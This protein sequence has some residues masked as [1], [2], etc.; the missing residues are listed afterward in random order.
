MRSTR[1]TATVSHAPA[2]CDDAPLLQYAPGQGAQDL[3]VASLLRKS[4]RFDTRS[5]VASQ[6]ALGIAL[7][8]PNEM[9]HAERI[10]ENPQERAHQPF[11]E[12]G[13]CPM[14]RVEQNRE[15]IVTPALATVQQQLSR[16]PYLASLSL[17]VR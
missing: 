2:L 1:R 7:E 9:P 14:A 16:R 17:F 6:L 13:K 8:I 15:F 3:G 12:S 11:Q 4:H 10:E 5:T